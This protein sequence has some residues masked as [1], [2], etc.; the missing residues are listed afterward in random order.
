MWS[1]KVHVKVKEDEVQGPMHAGDE[2]LKQLKSLCDNRLVLACTM[3]T[4]EENYRRMLVL[5]A[6]CTPIE[7]WHSEQNTRCRSTHENLKFMKEQCM[8][9]SWEPL[10]ATMENI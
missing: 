1:D 3:Y 4:D 6:S 10:L 8:G 9:G 7:K 5:C 2:Q